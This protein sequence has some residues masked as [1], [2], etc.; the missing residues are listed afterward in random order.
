MSPRRLT[1][2]FLL[3]ALIAGC[4]SDGGSSSSG[5]SASEVLKKAGTQTAK[6]A[7]VKVELEATVNGAQDF[8][9]PAKFKAS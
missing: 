1:P 2:L 3:L 6:S 5:Q 4:G 9:G 7:D 8:E